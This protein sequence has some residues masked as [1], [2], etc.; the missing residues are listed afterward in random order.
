MHPPD[1]RSKALEKLHP[2]ARLGWVGMERDADDENINKGQFALL[3]LYPKRAE[4]LYEPWNGRGPVFGSHFDPLQWQPCWLANFDPQEV[5]NG[6]FLAKVKRWMTPMSK[7]VKE[8]AIEKGKALEAEVSDITGD[9]GE[10]LYWAAQKA[11]DRPN[12][13]AKRH[14]GA[15]DK[16][17]LSG[18]NPPVDFTETF[19]PQALR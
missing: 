6:E 10:R 9:A 15:E 7:R 12:V 4:V 11:T 8:S 1:H 14:M 19:V 3:Q 16:A 2:R 13:V 18:D 17:V 5:F